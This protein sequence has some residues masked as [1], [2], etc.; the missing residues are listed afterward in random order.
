[1]MKGRRQESEVR[2]ILARATPILL[3]VTLFLIFDF[4]LLSAHAD[5]L[6]PTS[7]DRM[8]LHEVDALRHQVEQ[9]WNVPIT[10]PNAG[11]FAVKV[12][13]NINPDRTVKSADVV[14]QNRMAKDPNFK[15]VAESVI[16]AIFNPKCSPLELPESKYDQW[17]TIDF[18]FDP[19]DML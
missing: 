11:N 10:P 4:C 9:C 17:K 3:F 19:R 18:T 7:N 16:H 1:M 6:P 13:L 5:P 8:T 15:I 12:R 14:D 2:K